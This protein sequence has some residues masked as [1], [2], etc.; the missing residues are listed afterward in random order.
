[1][2]GPKDYLNKT[3][4]EI[5]ETI[6][7]GSLNG[8]FHTMPEEAY[9]RYPTYQ[10]AEIERSSGLSTGCRNGNSYIILGKDRN[11]DLSTGFGGTKN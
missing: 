7:L 2:T 5:M 1:M 11:G 6:E 4:K 3:P 9:E 8:Q 10:Y